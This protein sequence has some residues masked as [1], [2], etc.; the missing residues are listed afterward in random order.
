[1]GIGFRI[2]DFIQFHVLIE[3]EIKKKLV[4]CSEVCRTYSRQTFLALL[5]LYFMM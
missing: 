4:G 5:R 2:H 1:M 3:E